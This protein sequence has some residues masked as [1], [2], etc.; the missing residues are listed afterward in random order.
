[1]LIELDESLLHLAN[2]NNESLIVVC[3]AIN[4]IALARRDGHHFLYAERG[5]LESLCLLPQLNVLTLS[6]M[7][8]VINRFPE[9]AA[10]AEQLSVTVLIGNFPLTQVVVNGPRTVVKVPVARVNLT[11][12]Q[13]TY[14]LVENLI[15]AKFYS[16]IA[17]SRVAGNI[18][19]NFE[20]YPGGGDTTAEVLDHIAGLNRMCL[21][22]V[23]SDR[24]Y[25]NGPLG[26]TAKKV[27][28][29]SEELGTSLTAY[30]VLPV[31]SIENLIPM[32]LLKICAKSD[33]GQTTRIENLAELYRDDIWPYFGLKRGIKCGDVV[34][35]IKPGETFWR[36]IA[37]AHPLVKKCATEGP[38]Q[39]CLR[40]C[41]KYIFNSLGPNTLKLAI[42]ELDRSGA[43]VAYDTLPTVQSARE[44]LNN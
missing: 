4:T 30:Y 33:A 40:K 41:D 21:C 20:A 10:M 3:N 18:P 9:K 12:V 39:I 2:S 5:L 29:V 43:A 34:E 19:I 32:D 17:K 44:A 16:L 27:V 11:F 14:L 25:P 31:S 38:D 24:R 23:D 28:R 35:N 36:G 13:K 22:I 7:R 8:R 42:A 37:G 1:M 26:G 15:D 6:L